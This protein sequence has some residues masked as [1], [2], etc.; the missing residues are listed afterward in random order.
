VVSG[1][2]DY[3]LTVLARDVDAFFAHMRSYEAAFPSLRRIRTFMLGDELKS[4][5]IVPVEA[6]GPDH[7]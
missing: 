4:R 3:A 1:D 6:T 5:N 7:D 2:A